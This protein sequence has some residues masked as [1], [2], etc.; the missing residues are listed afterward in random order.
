MHGGE[1]SASLYSVYATFAQCVYK[2]TSYFQKFVLFLR[3]A[4]AT[5]CVDGRG[6]K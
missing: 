6:G 1:A 5:P 4:L 2:A 3:C